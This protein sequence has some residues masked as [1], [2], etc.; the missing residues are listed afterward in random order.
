[1][2]VLAYVVY[3]SI[4]DHVMI[5]LKNLAFEFSNGRVYMNEYF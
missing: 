4:S 1:M 2:D 5:P 3:C